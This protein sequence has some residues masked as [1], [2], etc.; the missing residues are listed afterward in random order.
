MDYYNITSN[1]MPNGSN[2]CMNIMPW[3][4]AIVNRIALRPKTK[5]LKNST[6]YLSKHK[7]CFAGD[8][9]RN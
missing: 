4:L 3:S 5:V 9:Y 6:C 7:Y 2:H 1:I 8:E